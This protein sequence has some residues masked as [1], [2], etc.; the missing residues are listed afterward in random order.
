[1]SASTHLSFIFVT[2]SSFHHGYLSRKAEGNGPMKPWQPIPFNQVKGKGA[3][4]ITNPEHSR[5]GVTDKSDCSHF[6]MIAF[7]IY[8]EGFFMPATFW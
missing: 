4:S 5:K 2:I 1:V 8:Q 6:F 7:L 3:N